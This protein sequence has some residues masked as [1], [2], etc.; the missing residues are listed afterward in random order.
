MPPIA[1][2]SPRSMERLS[3]SWSSQWSQARIRACCKTGSWSMSSPTSL[4][5]RL[6]EAGR[7]APAAHAD[8][9]GD[10]RLQLVAR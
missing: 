7:D 1:L 8:R 2:R 3:G 10:D 4:S 9:T 5:R 6:H